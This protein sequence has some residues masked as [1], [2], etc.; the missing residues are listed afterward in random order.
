MGENSYWSVARMADRINQDNRYRVLVEKLMQLEP[1]DWLKFQ[2]QE[3]NLQTA[4]L[5]TSQCK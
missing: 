5:Q 3:K 1:N 2:E 4:E